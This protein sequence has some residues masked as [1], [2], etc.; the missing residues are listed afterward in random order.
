MLTVARLSR[1]I[2]AALSALTVTACQGEDPTEPG[3]T[4]PY[5][6]IVERRDGPSG[7]PDLYVLDLTAGEERR[8]LS[9]GQGGMHP[10]AS[11]TGDRVVFVRMDG[12]FTSEIF[13]VNARD[14]T[15]QT[16]LSNHAQPDAMP[17][18]S[19]AGSRIA[20]VSD[21][22][23]YQD[24]FVVNTD[25]TGLRQIGFADPSPGVATDWWPNW[26]PDGTRIAF[27][28]TIDGTA[29]IWTTTVDATPI[30][31]ERLTGTLDS[32]THPTWNVD[33]TRIA[34]ERHDMNTG[35][36]DI[37]V[38]TLSTQTLQR[39]Q[40]PGQ[41]LSPAWS[42]NGELIAFASNHE[43]DPDHEIYTMRPDGTEITRRT[44]NG[45]LDLRPAWLLRPT[46]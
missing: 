16:N 30:I 11:P 17:A 37:Y 40:L 28:S 31:R 8:L 3:E 1:C 35:D 19:R 9:A 13:L 23:G 29:D 42:P 41:Q 7:P 20:F 6:I 33:G 24:I 26:S 5:D 10:Y 32:D 43:G 14:G 22:M 34:F 46:P 39:I 18:W 2:S 4:F 15:G 45:F 21:R 38:L 27:S 44:D 12:Q 25:G 36:A